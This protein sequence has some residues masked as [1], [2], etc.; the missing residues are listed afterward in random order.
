[1]KKNTYYYNNKKNYKNKNYYKNKPNNYNHYNENSTNISTNDEKSTKIEENNLKNNKNNENHGIRIDIKE[2]FTN[3]KIEEP[4]ELN[5]SFESN[6]NEFSQYKEEKI[7]YLIFP[8]Y[9][10]SAN[11]I[12]NEKSIHEQFI[13]ISQPNYEN[14]IDNSKKIEIDIPKDNELLNNPKSTKYEEELNEINLP[15]KTLIEIDNA[16]NTTDIDNLGYLY[17]ESAI[18]AINQ[19]LPIIPIREIEKEI[20]KYECILKETFREIV[21]NIIKVNN[22]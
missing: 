20:Y 13:N 21:I 15:Y 19:L 17:L 12:E 6:K 11:K 14:E 2:I 8:Q 10:D 18:N 7:N 3:N 1:M 16:F 22:I 9:K 5:L 4:P